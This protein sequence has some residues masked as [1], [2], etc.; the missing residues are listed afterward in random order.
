MNE[1]QVFKSGP[2]AGQP[3]TLTDRV[4]RFLVDGLK[5][6][7]Q[8]AFYRS[9]YRLF[10]S[11]HTNRR[12]FIGKAGAIR[13]GRTVS[14]SVSITTEFHVNMM[15]WEKRLLIVVDKYNGILEDQCPCN[16]PKPA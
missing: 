5:M 16:K 3:K 12:Y 8:E 4:V 6:Q 13:A 11:K 2:R 7:E 14:D 10:I 9:K 1:Y 15:M